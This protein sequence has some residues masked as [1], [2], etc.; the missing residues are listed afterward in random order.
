MMRRRRTWT[1]REAV[2]G[3]LA[4]FAGERVAVPV[5]LV[6]DRRAKLTEAVLERFSR[7]VWR[8]AERDFGRGGI[9]LRAGQGTGEMGR[10]ASGRP[11]FKGL[12]HGVV[13]VVLTEA[14]PMEWDR[15]RQLAGLTTQYDGEHLCL[16]AVPRAHGHQI[17]LLS[18]NT[19]VHE[20]LHVLMGDILEKRPKGWEGDGREVRID[21]AA[22]KLWL[23]G[24]GAEIRQGAR[25]YLRRRGT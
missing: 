1:R 17:P 11:V 2:A 7:E 15:G 25:E 6:V 19:C 18:V 10:A 20:L 16:I 12:A 4:A 23:F 5:Y 22:T 9:H 13:N 14:I 3:G 24:D 21:W 8:E